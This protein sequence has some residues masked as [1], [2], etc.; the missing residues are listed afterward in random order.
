[1]ENQLEIQDLIDIVGNVGDWIVFAYLFISERK[2]HRRTIE[3]WN[4]DL[5]D[6]AGLNA[7]LKTINNDMSPK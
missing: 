5:R 6:I 4:D 3:R 7:R 2:A 1:M